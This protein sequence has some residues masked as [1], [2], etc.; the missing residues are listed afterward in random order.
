MK[1][2]PCKRKGGRFFFLTRRLCSAFSSSRARARSRAS[3]LLRLLFACPPINQRSGPIPTAL[4]GLASLNKLR[5][6]NNQLEGERE[7][8][9]HGDRSTCSARTICWEIS[10]RVCWGKEAMVVVLMTMKIN[11]EVEA[12]VCCGAHAAWASL[13][14]RF[15]F[16]LCIFFA[17]SIFFSSRFSFLDTNVAQP[18]S[19]SIPVELG[20]L[21]KLQY[22]NL[23]YNGAGNNLTGELM[24]VTWCFFQPSPVFCGEA[25]NFC[26]P[27]DSTPAF[28]VQVIV[29]VQVFGRLVYVFLGSCSAGCLL[30]VVSRALPS[31]LSLT[32]PHPFPPLLF[33]CV[34]VYLSACLSLF[35]SFLF[36]L[37][38]VPIGAGEI[39]VRAFAK[40]PHLAWLSMTDN[41][42][43]A[44]L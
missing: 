10:V 24:L 32:C 8:G 43:L 44:G 21:T 22:V 17:R 11:Y 40:M 39:P 27:P 19:G 28:E 29:S 36:S 2:V 14:I 6:E 31:P 18:C 38:V 16:F 13:T 12:W 15:F 9:Q 3:P 25:M 5:L 20:M 26:V 1:G 35:L 34:S 30:L 33:P 4:G 23:G 37:P 7:E 42:R 41:P